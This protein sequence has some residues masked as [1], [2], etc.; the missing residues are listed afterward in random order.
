MFAVKIR[1]SH[2]YFVVLL[3]REH[4]FRHG[5]VLNMSE[6]VNKL[7]NMKNI[8]YI[9]CITLLLIETSYTQI[10]SII[11]ELEI[12]VQTKVNLLG[13][14]DILV[15]TYLDSLGTIYM[16]AGHINK[17][18][19]LF[20]RALGIKN[21]ASK[22]DKIGL[23]KSYDN[24]G[25]LQLSKGHSE[26]AD[27]LFNVAYN[28]KLIELGPEH[29]Y[30]SISYTNF[31]EVYLQ[32]GDYEKA[33]SFCH[34]ALDI[35]VEH[36]GET[37]ST[38]AAT[39]NL[40]GLVHVKLGN[41]KKAVSFHNKALQIELN[42]FGATHLDVAK[43]YA[44]LGIVQSYIGDYDKALDNHEKAL[45]I[46]R[47]AYGEVHL[48][49]AYAHHNLGT[50]YYKMGN[51]DKSARFYLKAL[52]LKSE[53][54]GEKDRG[55][56]LTCSNLGALYK[57]TGDYEKA[58]HYG[59][60]ALE[61]RQEILGEMH[62][63]VANS[64]NNIANIYTRTGDLE[65]ATDLYLKA[66][67]IREKVF[68]KDHPNVA[69]SYHNLGNLYNHTE[70]YEN[71]VYYGNKAL[72]VWTAVYGENHPHVSSS[73]ANLTVAY[74]G[75]G[76]LKTADSLWHLIIHK[77]LKRLNN[78]FLFLPDK[79]RLDFAETFNNVHEAF[80]RYTIENEN[81]ITRK[82]AAYLLLN[83][84]AL[85]LDYSISVRDIINNIESEELEIL[86]GELISLNKNISQAELITKEQRKEQ[87]LNIT[88]MHD[89]Q[90]DL[91][92]QLLQN[93]VLKEK[94]HKEPIRWEDALAKLH[95]D[96]AILDFMQFNNTY[97][98][99]LSLKHMSAPQIIRI[100]DQE[101]ISTF[102]QPS[103]KDGQPKYI[104]HIEGLDSLFQKIWLPMNSQL[105]HVKKIHLSASGLLH[106]IDFE[107]LRNENG[108]FL[109]EQFEFHYYKTIRDFIN[110]EESSSYSNFKENSVS[111]NA[112]LLGDIT[113]D[114]SLIQKDNNTKAILR[115]GIEP[116][117]ATQKEIIEIA[118]IIEENDGSF[119][120]L[121]G[122][123]ASE[124]IIQNNSGDKS[125]DIYH[126]ATHGKYLLPLDSLGAD[127]NL[128]KRMQSSDNAL[129][130]SM[131]ML[132]GANQTWTSEENIK[133][134][135]DDGILTAY[136]ISNM[137]FR[138]TDLVVLSACNT[139][140][141][142]I[143]DT[144][145][146]IGLQSAFKL[147]GVEN[148][149]VSLWKVNDVAT[150]DLMVLFYENY[151]TK[152]QDIATSLRTAKATMKNRGAKPQNWAGFILI[153]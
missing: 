130:R 92:R 98:V 85:A 148:I 81:P 87:G 25:L 147:A 38:L 5:F 145:G 66:L 94:L 23:A 84:K 58:I 49:L 117:P 44:S 18:D 143:H 132:S 79:Q 45:H 54:L 136:E 76:E 37:H 152:K 61:I 42:N 122:N 64:Y 9:L 89:Q 115:D 3:Y 20:I 77:N 93:S 24:L 43:Y 128:Q 150:K 32:K 86:Y 140:L 127:G 67:H 29:P 14:N 1:I 91:T 124:S 70:D 65:K 99:V 63:D 27:S 52:E 11:G 104:Q 141:G 116:L 46:W 36:Y 71:A 146:V 39:Y 119:T 103:G 69:S 125:P 62:V 129:Q 10:D 153:E 53:L 134:S 90:D 82:L 41:L 151:L 144:E 6:P 107:V 26:L 73:Y 112:I 15:A 96:E 16:D 59:S 133:L 106:Q 47:G 72:K 88:A 108:Q 55:V 95:A 123:R 105:S 78:N 118:K 126:F 109:G 137:D 13:S 21:Q 30:T 50:V 110:K 40:K 100:T 102:L 75:L 12:T 17:A 35:Q 113:Y 135:D 139:G 19:S 101:N 2:F 111:K 149:L 97:Y 34:K 131:L 138:N 74:E 142:D 22:N 31:G 4:I 56:A 120:R 121:S 8:I 28:I 83:T 57:L 7:I 114:K 48:K 60:R 33:L 68:K 80:F 51:Y